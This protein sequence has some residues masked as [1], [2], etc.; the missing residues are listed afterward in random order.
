MHAAA[1][2]DSVLEAFD[3]VLAIGRRSRERS[4]GAD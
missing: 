4:T 2:V 1:A 3:P